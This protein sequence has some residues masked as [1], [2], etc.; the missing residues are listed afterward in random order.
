MKKTLGRLF[1]VLGE[2]LDDKE[3][4]DDA[5]HWCIHREPPAFSEQNPV[6][7]ILVTGIKV[8]DLLGTLCQRW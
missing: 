7:E 1:N 2:T 6:V 5:E 3:E 4:L 8:I